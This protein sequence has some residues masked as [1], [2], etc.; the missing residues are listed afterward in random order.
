MFTI[1][2]VISIKITNKTNIYNNKI[3]IQIP[4][5]KQEIPVIILF[6]ALGFTNDREIIQLI[7][8]NNTKNL[9]KV[10]TKILLPSF[11][12]AKNIN[13]EYDCFVYITKYLQNTYNNIAN[14]SKIKYIKDTII[15]DYMPHVSGIKKK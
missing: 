12:E 6:R 15:K 1:P 7:I 11:E 8:D 4:G 13:T 2:K 3:R 14:E 5:L 10:M 9:D